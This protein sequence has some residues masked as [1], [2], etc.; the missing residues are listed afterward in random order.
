M[1]SNIKYNNQCSVGSF[2]NEYIFRLVVDNANEYSH[3]NAWWHI[4]QL[5]GPE[6]GV[7][8]THYRR[9]DMCVHSTIIQYEPLVGGSAIDSVGVSHTGALAQAQWHYGLS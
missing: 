8:M 3:S 1:S 2:A 5:F 9:S 6:W 4:Q 7:V